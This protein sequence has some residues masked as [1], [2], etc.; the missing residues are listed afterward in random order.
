[1]GEY[2]MRHWKCQLKMF[3]TL[4]DGL[5]GS[6]SWPCTPHE[7]LEVIEEGRRNC[8]PF[9]PSDF[10]DHFSG[11]KRSSNSSYLLPSLP[12]PHEEC[13]LQTPMFN[14]HKFGNYAATWL[15]YSVVKLMPG[16]EESLSSPQNALTNTI[17]CSFS[18]SL[19]KLFKEKIKLWSW[20]GFSPAVS[21]FGWCIEGTSHATGVHSQRKA[22]GIG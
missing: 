10:A 14:D 17:T 6:I 12:A 21:Q 4:F 15:H 20:L 19:C 5:W 13:T 22:G 3:L 8:L 9:P 11:K 2:T 7:V 1:M 16:W 18:G